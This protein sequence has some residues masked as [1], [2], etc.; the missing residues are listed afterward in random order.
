MRGTCQSSVFAIFDGS[1]VLVYLPNLPRLECGENFRDIYIYN[2]IIIYIYANIYIIQYHTHTTRNN[3]FF[4]REAFVME[5]A[6]KM[7]S[8]ENKM[9]MRSSLCVHHSI[10]L[11]KE[12]REGVRGICGLTVK[13]LFPFDSSLYARMPRHHIIVV[14]VSHALHKK[15]STQQFK[16]W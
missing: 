3:L 9:W 14:R 15:L 13:C 2:I 11:E 8:S 4:E 12:K 7:Q 5:K 6:C 10:Y 16:H 1:L